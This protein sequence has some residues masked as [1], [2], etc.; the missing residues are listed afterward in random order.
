MLTKLP[1]IILT[2]LSLI[3]SA[4]N[5]R[6]ADQPWFSAVS[7]NS[8]T[9]EDFSVEFLPVAPYHVGDV[10]SIRVTYEGFD[11]VDGQDIL[12]ALATDPNSILATATFSQGSSQAVFYWVLDTSGAQPGWINFLF[13][14]P[15]KDIT[16]TEGIHLLPRPNNRASE[17]IVVNTTC[18]SIHTLTGTDAENDLQK[19][20]EILEERSAQALAQFF[21]QGA[22][23][24]NLEKDPLS[25]V[26][27]PIVVGHG[28]FATHEAVMTY[29]HRNWAG[30]SFESL[31]HH[32]LVHVLDRQYNDQGPRP[33]LFAEGIAVY[34]SGGHYREGDPLDRAAALLALDM[35]IPITEITDDFYAAQHEIGY[36]EAAALVA[37]LVDVWGWNTFID[38]YFNLPEGETDTAIITSALQRQFSIDLV[39]LE[40]NFI[41]YLQNIEPDDRVK[42]DVRLTVEVYDMI[43]RYQTIAF[44]SAHFRTAWWPPIGRMRESGIVGDYAY[45]EKAPFNII[46][47]SLFL[48]IHAGFRTEDYKT[49]EEN[50]AMIDQYLGLVESPEVPLSHYS[51]GWPLP[52]LPG[53]ATRP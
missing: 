8:T 45:R 50:L 3:L 24:E 43:R 19:I 23:D 1:L 25:I 47:E 5:V 36:M 14:V 42:T 13:T 53:T 34:L 35:Y 11:Q 9:P 41:A 38:F 7:D 44:P 48:D 39:D 51:I 18:C 6:P 40:K 52:K 15:E 28:G 22:P 37:F 10:L 29:S 49:I 16:W 32:E 20:I 33:A 12:L 26:L 31:A 17:W 2:A 30:I 27:V 46:I 4:G 21:P